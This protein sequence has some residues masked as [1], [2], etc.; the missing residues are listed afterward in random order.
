MNEIL[1][2]DSHDNILPSDNN[3]NIDT[4][5]EITGFKKLTIWKYTA[6]VPVIQWAAAIDIL[7]AESA[8]NVAK[9]WGFGTLSCFGIHKALRYREYRQK[10]VR[11][12]YD[13]IDLQE[14]K[15]ERKSLE[16]EI[17]SEEYQNLISENTQS[18]KTDTGNNYIKNAFQEIRKLSKET[19]ISWGKFEIFFANLKDKLYEKE[20]LSAAGSLSLEEYKKLIQDEYKRYLTEEYK[21]PVVEADI[22]CFRKE[23]KK[24]REISGW[25]WQIFINVLHAA[26]HQE[27]RIKGVI[28]DRYDEDDGTYNEWIK[29]IIQWAWFPKDLPGYVEGHDDIALW[30]IS[31]NWKSVKLVFDIRWDKYKRLPDR[32]TLEDPREAAWHNWSDTDIAFTV[33]QIKEYCESKWRTKPIKVIAAGGILDRKDIDDRLAQWADGV[34]I[35]SG[36][37][38][39]VES[40]ANS[41]Y[42]NAIIQADNGTENIEETIEVEVE[43]RV[44]EK[45]INKKKVYKAIKEYMSNACMLA[46]GLSVSPVFTKIENIQA[47]QRN[48][49]ENCLTHC[50]YRDGITD[51]PVPKEETDDGKIIRKQNMPTAQM[52]IFREL[53][54]QQLRFIG[55]TATRINKIKSTKAYMDELKTPNDNKL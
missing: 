11:T 2:H 42:K 21:K 47:E 43:K 54:N 28:E 55:N 38:G 29:W 1:N 22:Y 12:R 51:R 3:E 32:V 46:R 30:I 4:I 48:C 18:S 8:G 6:E 34:Q 17:A 25:K 20:R 33:Q 7:R 39:T 44:W 24:A 45:R 31:W 10:L 23:L 15:R 27:A 9:E 26:S 13:E 49:I 52:C 35:W 41:D 37:V 53:I 36:F 40:A 14:K 50:A 16:V 19:D 5:N